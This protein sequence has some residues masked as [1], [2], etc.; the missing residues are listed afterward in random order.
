MALGAFLKREA[1]VLVR[2]KTAFSERCTGL[3]TTL[4]VILGCVV[5][6]DWLEYDRTSAAGM[7]SY[8]LAAFGLCVALQVMLL[9]GLVITSASASIASERDRK[10]LD[11]LLATR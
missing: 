5:A 11:A 7:H 6:C 9:S 4:V 8:S 2:R 1:I 10:T 3:A